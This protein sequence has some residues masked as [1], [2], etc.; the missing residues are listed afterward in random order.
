GRVIYTREGQD[1]DVYSL[2]KDEMR[3]LRWQYI[4]YI[5]QGAMSIF[6]PVIKIKD[7]Y[8]DFM[9]SHLSG[10][11]EKEMFEIASD[12]IDKLGLPTKI[13]D[14]YPHQLSG[15]MRQRVAIALAALLEP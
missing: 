9:D 10:K 2:S 15:G 1:I 5:P 7:T 11:T 14:A 12:H 3:Q 8:G 4:A 6:N 13:L